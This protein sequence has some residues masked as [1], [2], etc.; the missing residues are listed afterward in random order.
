MFYHRVLTLTGAPQRLSTALA[1]PTV[2]GPD[3][4]PCRQVTF[5]AMGANGNPIYI[6]GDVTVAVN[7]HALRINAGTQGV[8]D[9]PIILGGFDSGPLKLS[10]FWVLGTG[11][12]VLCIGM[13]PF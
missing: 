13:I 9:P 8:P 2:G 4:R 10:D 5:Q 1:D 12:Q 3:D 7:N 6:G 11:N